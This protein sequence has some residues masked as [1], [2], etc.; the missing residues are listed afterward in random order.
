MVPERLQKDCTA[1]EDE[2]LALEFTSV[3]SSIPTDSE[4]STVSLQ[5]TT[6]IRQ[7]FLAIVDAVTSLLKLSIVIRNPAP[8]DRYHKSASIE[9]FDDSFDIAHVWHKFPHARHTPWLI[10]R[11]GKANTRRRQ[12]LK[13][14]ERHRE[15]LA[16]EP[17]P[18]KDG[19]DPQKGSIQKGASGQDDRGNR[20]R[21]GPNDA[22]GQSRVL[23]MLH[24]STFA[25]TTAST[26]V[27]ND[28]DKTDERSSAG[29]SETS[30]ATSVNEDGE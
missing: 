8:R 10:E 29:E 22:D 4:G 19:E 27:L 25:P 1:T 2:D 12:H 16:K 26:Y 17:K 21:K 18:G 6:E 9:K 13:Y 7:L 20:R 30:Y 3:A 28:L 15:K 11:L 24:P 14:R 23:G 5:Q